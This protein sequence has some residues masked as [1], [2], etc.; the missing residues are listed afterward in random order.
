[1]FLVMLRYAMDDFPIQFFDSEFYAIEFAKKMSWD[2]PADIYDAIGTD[3]SIPSSIC[4]YQFTNNR[5]SGIVFRRSYDE[6]D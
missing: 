3:A 2:I 4:V 6:E 5:P 1:M